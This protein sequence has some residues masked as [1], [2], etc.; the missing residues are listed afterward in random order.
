MSFPNQNSLQGTIQ[1][2]KEIVTNVQG[3]DHEAYQ[4]VRQME[5]LVAEI[6]RKTYKGRSEQASSVAV[7]T[8]PAA[9]TTSPA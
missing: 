8:G 5:F 6:E 2:L 9:A 3:E 1:Q 4:L 7:A